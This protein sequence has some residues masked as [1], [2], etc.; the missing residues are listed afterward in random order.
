MD[1]SSW[2]FYFELKHSLSLSVLK[3][4]KRMFISTVS[5]HDHFSV[6]ANPLRHR[7]SPRR[8]PPP[9]SHKLTEY[10][11]V[12]RSTRAPQHKAKGEPL[13]S[14]HDKL[15][16]IC[17]HGLRVGCRAF[18]LV[19]FCAFCDFLLCCIYTLLC[20]MLRFFTFGS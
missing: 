3:R 6:P 7:G 17:Q 1:R 12:R 18:C 9:K 15:R 4:G 20:C 11:F 16:T 10:Y 19:V 2:V 13:H 5:E 14:L 8:S